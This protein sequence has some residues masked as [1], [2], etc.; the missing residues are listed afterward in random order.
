MS[1]NESIGEAGMDRALDQADS[2]TGADGVSVRL[3]D[4]TPHR[5]AALLAWLRRHEW[6]TGTEPL[7]VRLRE[8]VAADEAR[9]GVQG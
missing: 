5:R 8:L 9:N 2:W 6:C 3:V 1:G 7:Y 4:M